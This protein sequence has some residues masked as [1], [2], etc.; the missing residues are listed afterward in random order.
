MNL[1]L[2]HPVGKKR[3]GKSS[4]LEKVNE[5]TTEETIDLKEYGRVKLRPIHV[6]DERLMVRFHESL[7]EEDIYRRYFEHISLDTRTLHERLSRICRNTADSFAIVAERHGPAHRGPEILAVGR[8]TTTEKSG[9]GSFAILAG[10]KVQSSELPQSI[11][12]RLIVIARAHG[13]QTLAE[14]VLV[15]DHDALNLCRSFG[16]DMKTIPQDGIVEVK[17]SL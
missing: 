11:L 9:V 2:L 4:F 12:R 7:S 3:T 13:F 1:N 10:E 14:E 5:F 17:Y 6:D 8:L 16:F 15:A